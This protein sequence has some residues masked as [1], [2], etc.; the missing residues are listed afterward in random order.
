MHLPG[1]NKA[2]FRM[3]DWSRA[4]RFRLLVHCLRVVAGDTMPISHIRLFRDSQENLRDLESRRAP[5]IARALTARIGQTGTAFE[6]L[7]P[8]GECR[9][10]HH[11]TADIARQV[12]SIGATCLFNSLCPERYDVTLQ[13]RATRSYST[14][15]Q[16]CRRMLKIVS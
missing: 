12:S 4:T 10:V 6:R 15:T 2:K 9:Y 16:I 14:R 1:L 3:C 11:C 7:M 13:R 8:I 5:R